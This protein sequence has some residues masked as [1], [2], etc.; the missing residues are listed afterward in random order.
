MSPPGM[1]PLAAAIAILL[2]VIIRSIRSGISWQAIDDGEATVEVLRDITGIMDYEKLQEIFGPPRL[3][4]GVFPVTREEVKRQRTG[5]GYL[6]GD[7]W[8]D[9]AS[10][11][12][13]AVSL[14]PIWPMWQSSVWLSSL[15]TFALAY[16]ICGWIA[17]SR[18]IGRR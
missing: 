8:L 16:Q 18:L 14:L 10:A 15:L 11:L 5:L 2:S 9:G 13:G 6:I 12:I 4:D 3:L 7:K 1:T 17:S